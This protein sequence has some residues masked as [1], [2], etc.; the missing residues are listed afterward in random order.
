MIFREGWGGGILLIKGRVIF[1][2]LGSFLVFR[3]GE[4]GLF[5]RNVGRVLFSIMLYVKGNI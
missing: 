5:E 3:G 4:G 2:I 1:F